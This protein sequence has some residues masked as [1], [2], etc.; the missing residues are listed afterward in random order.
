[1]E[2]DQD[3]EVVPV[4]ESTLV[5]RRTIDTSPVGS[6]DRLPLSVGRPPVVFTLLTAY[7][8][9]PT[10]T[11]VVPELPVMDTLVPPVTYTPVPS[12]LALPVSDVTAPIRVVEVVPVEMV[13]APAALETRTELL[14]VTATSDPPLV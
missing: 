13:T 8:A 3:G 1:V 5:V 10:F 2:E 7:G 12:P 4:V 14:A 6:V 9:V 11:A